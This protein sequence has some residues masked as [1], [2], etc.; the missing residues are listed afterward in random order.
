M[1][2]KQISALKIQI[3][4]TVNICLFI[5]FLQ[6]LDIIK[7]YFDIWY[8]IKINAFLQDMKFDFTLLLLELQYFRREH[9]SYESERLW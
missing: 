6:S 4:F 7:K 8:S 5:I 9:E 3:C 2:N 1:S